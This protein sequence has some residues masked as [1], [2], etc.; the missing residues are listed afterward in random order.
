[1]APPLLL[2]APARTRTW[3]YNQRRR[4]LRGLTRRRPR[5]VFVSFADGERFTT[6]YVVEDV[7]RLGIF[8][9]VLGFAPA[10]LGEEFWAQHGAFVRANPT[11]YGCWVWKI[12][13]LHHMLQRLRADDILVYADAGCTVTGNEA[14]QAAMLSL[15]ARL[16]NAPCG[17][18]ARRMR[19]L[20]IRRFCKADTW[21]GLGVR[22][23]ELAQMH[24][25]MSNKY[26]LRKCPAAMR[27]VGAGMALLQA[28]LY[29]LF[30]DTESR[31]PNLSQFS[32]HRHDQA[33]L[34]ILFNRYGCEPWEEADDMFYAAR[35]AADDFA[36]R[37][38]GEPLAR[39]QDE[40]MSSDERRRDQAMIRQWLVWRRAHGGL[41]QAAQRLLD[42]LPETKEIPPLGA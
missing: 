8:D 36:Q 24:L 28:Q 37:L 19:H 14:A 32:A 27:V 4:V 29:H 17:I 22:E 11:G 13:L 35:F 10:D 15:F 38:A 16:Q 42:S 30:D 1:M 21:R 12:W 9:E 18:A 23:A 20:D 26:V 39:W 33:V 7:R 3:L 25:Y 41:P 2:R 5:K 6:S 31:S 34:S 40:A